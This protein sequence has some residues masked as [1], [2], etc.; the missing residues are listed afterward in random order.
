MKFAPE[1][2]SCVLE[3]DFSDARRLFLSQ[4]PAI[5]YAHLVMLADRGIVAPEDALALRKALDA[6]PLAKVRAVEFDGGRADLFCFVTREIE[7]RG[8][9]ER[10]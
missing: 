9:S 3:A 10:L 8:R 7:R 1:Y 4:L 2:T 5:H 6:I